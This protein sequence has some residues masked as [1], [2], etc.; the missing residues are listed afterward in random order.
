M[1]FIGWLFGA[2]AAVPP[3]AMELDG[4]TEATLAR[5]LVDVAT[6]RAGMDYVW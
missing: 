2:D 1:S 5:F 4:T 6:G 3:D